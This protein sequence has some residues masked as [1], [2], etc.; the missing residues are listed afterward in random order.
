ML[1]QIER[2]FETGLEV[3]LRRWLRGSLQPIEIAKAAA[4]AMEASE[5]LGPGG[6]RVANRYR[7]R[8]SP[9]DFR[10]FES[11]RQ[12]L[13]RDV[14]LYLDAEAARLGVR[15]LDV[16]VV[17]VDADPGVQPGGV[18]INAEKVDIAAGLASEQAGADATQRL[19][20]ATPALTRSRGRLVVGEQA[21]LLSGHL[22][23]IGRALDNDIVVADSR[24]SRYHA[25][26]EV[27]DGGFRIRDL[28]STNGTFVAG[29]RIA[30][31]A[32]VPGEEVSLGGLAARLELVD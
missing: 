3:R 18:R 8:L 9:A 6:P 19:N 23:T 31:A 26:V 28:A 4:R 7:V 14:E 10:R 30:E 22:T 27:L 24:V 16:W 32:L 11:Y 17:E 25:H 29:R 1:R 13:A 12:S 21:F 20:L 2:L 15:P 5:V